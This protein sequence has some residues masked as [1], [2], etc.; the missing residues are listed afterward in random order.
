[1]NYENLLEIATKRRSIRS[2]TNKKVSRDDIE[3]IVNVA[4]QSPSGFNSQPWEFVVVDD[5]NFRKEVTQYILEAIGEGKTSKGFVNAPVYIILYG[6][7]SVRE[8]GPIS[9]KDDDNWWDFTFSAT[10][11]SAFMSMQ[12]AA[13]SLGLGAM[14]VSTFRNPTVDKKAKELLGIPKHLQIFEMLAVGYTDMK[15]S[16][17][18]LRP[19]SEVLHYNKDDNY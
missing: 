3:K 16:P 19:V 5:D 2:F 18:K 15:L 8:N 4:I 11:A 12:L 1:M 7:P 17:K 13:T 14:W 6:D 10:L 9:V